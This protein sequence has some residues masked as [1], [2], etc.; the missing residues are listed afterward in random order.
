VGEVSDAV[1]ASFLVA[2]RMKGETVDEL[3]GFVREMR[4]HAVRIS[5]RHPVV[6][7]TCGT[8]GDCSRTFNISTLAAFVVAGCGVPVAKHGNR[9]ISSDCGSADL[10]ERLGVRIDAPVLVTQRCL[11]EIGIAF[12]FAPLFHP[13]LKRAAGVRKELGLR[14]VFNILGP[15]CNP[16]DANCQLLGVSQEAMAKK[17][18][19]VLRR[20]GRK[21]AFVVCSE[22]GMD[23]ISLSCATKVYCLKN[24]K[25]SHY[26]F[27]PEDVRLKCASPRALVGGS[28]DDNAA[29]ARRI[30]QGKKG[31]KRDAVVLNAAFGL[32][33]A[34]RVKRLQDGIRMAKESL[35]SGQA[36]IKLNQL[37]QMT[38]NLQVVG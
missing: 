29:I 15:L 28:P 20:L 22:C 37:V 7:D 19:Q 36:K 1:L 26:R 4:V 34:G 32:L 16:A 13:A 2:L 38:Q 31:P 25:I 33:A 23:E 6:L 11:E 30:L 3:T 35:Y 9:S 8:G 12:L 21:R 17:V 27:R 24:R 18:I 10:L 5:S 14:T